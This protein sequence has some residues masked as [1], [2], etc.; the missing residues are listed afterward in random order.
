MYCRKQGE[1][2]AKCLE[3]FSKSGVP[4]A[5]HGTPRAMPCHVSLKT[6]H[7]VARLLEFWTWHGTPRATFFQNV[8]WHGTGIFFRARRGTRHAPRAPPSLNIWGWGAGGRLFGG[9]VPL[10]Q[11][12]FCA[13]ATHFISFQPLTEFWT[14]GDFTGVKTTTHPQNLAGFLPMDHTIDLRRHVVFTIQS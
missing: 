11:K 10:R 3:S 4:R 13:P 2:I 1:R 6:W 12:N 5:T 9:P 14:F 7:G 8:A